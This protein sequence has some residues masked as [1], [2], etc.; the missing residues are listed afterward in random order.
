MLALNNNGHETLSGGRQMLRNRQLL[1]KQ[2]LCVIAA[3]LFSLLGNA[4]LAQDLPPNTAAEK[5]SVKLSAGIDR[6]AMEEF[7]KGSRGSA[8][9]AFN[10]CH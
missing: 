4:G 3:G 9:G 7:L 8:K 10:R 1:K 6:A 2:G 5:E